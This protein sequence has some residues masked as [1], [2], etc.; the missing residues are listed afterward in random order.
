MTPSE[1]KT[2]LSYGP[3]KVLSAIGSG[4]QKRWQQTPRERSPR[5]DSRISHQVSWLRTL[6]LWHRQPAFTRRLPI[7]R[8]MMKREKSTIVE[9]CPADS[10][11]L[12][13]KTSLRSGLPHFILLE[14]LGWDDSAETAGRDNSRVGTSTHRKRKSIDDVEQN[15]SSQDH[16]P[17]R[18]TP[19]FVQSPPP[20]LSLWSHFPSRCLR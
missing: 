20:S 4:S 14:R 9:P 15:E 18:Y 7:E 11:D 2:N 13:R 3:T 12:F 19:D 8:A 6:H 5:H 17:R 10:C 16:S 1:P